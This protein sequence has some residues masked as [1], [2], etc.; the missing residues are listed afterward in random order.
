MGR[1]PE[2]N[3]GERERRYRRENAQGRGFNKFSL[4]NVIDKQSKRRFDLQP[5]LRTIYRP[6]VENSR[7]M[8]TEVD[9]IQLANR[10][11]VDSGRRLVEQKLQLALLTNR[12]SDNFCFGDSTSNSRNH[13]KYTF[14]GERNVPWNY[15]RVV[16]L[17]ST[18]NLLDFSNRWTKESA[19]SPKSRFE[20]NLR[21]KD[22]RQLLDT[23]SF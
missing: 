16:R 5:G 14:L 8:L 9:R 1:L 13:E 20:S 19:S 7:S 11:T 22:S 17:R 10:K 6:F 4:N 2:R 12:S 18:A 21:E 3:K 15:K 23:L